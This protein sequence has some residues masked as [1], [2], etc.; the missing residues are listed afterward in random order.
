MS[1]V[2][3]SMLIPQNKR[4]ADTF[5]LYL[6]VR[7]RVDNLAQ[8]AAGSKAKRLR[9]LSGNESASTGNAS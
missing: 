7:T 3:T 8:Q 5:H 1:D 4:L 9:D 6:V 2:N